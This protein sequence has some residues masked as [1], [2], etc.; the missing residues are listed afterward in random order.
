MHQSF[1]VSQWF[2]FFLSI[3]F[4]LVFFI[5]LK[6]RT[7]SFGIW[8]T[9]WLTF[10]I[11][12]AN[13]QPTNKANANVGFCSS[14]CYIKYRSRSILWTRERYKRVL[15]CNPPKKYN[16]LKQIKTSIISD[17]SLPL[18][19]QRDIPNKISCEERHNCKY[20][21]RAFSYFNPAC[22]K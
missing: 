16:F 9:V 5:Q 18:Y 4:S 10:I 2:L 8:N 20:G 6:N 1:V 11:N 22:S 19:Y 14:K 13:I 15:N 12:N 21:Y 17:H 7:G 3:F